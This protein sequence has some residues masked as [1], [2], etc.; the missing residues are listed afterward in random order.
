MLKNFSGA[1][2]QKLSEVSSLFK[3][4][5]ISLNWITKFACYYSH[6][7]LSPS[8]F[9]QLLQTLNDAQNPETQ[10][11]FSMCEIHHWPLFFFSEASK[12]YLANLWEEKLKYICDNVNRCD[13]EEKKSGKLF[14]HFSFTKKYFFPI[15]NPTWEAAR[16][17]KLDLWILFPFD[18]LPIY[19]RGMSGNR[20]RRKR[21]KLERSSNSSDRNRKRKWI[22]FKPYETHLPRNS[23]F[24]N[25]FFLGW[26]LRA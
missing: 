18:I 14:L 12:S 15:S 6:L 21:W 26:F 10:P 24:P 3:F 7:N 17:G 8:F 16:H 22:N 2:Q 23:F 9:H 11:T 25:S 19:T 13:H 5:M 20:K 1:F 4:K